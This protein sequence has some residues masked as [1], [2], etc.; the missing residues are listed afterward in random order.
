MTPLALALLFLL[1][2][3]AQSL[4]DPVPLLNGD[5]LNLLRLSRA[6]GAGSATIVPATG[7]GFSSALRL[8]TTALPANS[9]DLRVRA[10]GSAPVR[11]NDSILVTFYA[12][13]VQSATGACIILLNVEQTISPYTKSANIPLVT[14]PDWQLVRYVFSMADTYASGGYMIDFWMSQQ[15]Q[16]IE[17]GA[18][19]FNNYGPGVTAS[20]L[21]IPVYDGAEAGA[22]WRAAALDR[23]E[24][25]RKANLTIS[26]TGPNGNPIP[27]VSVRAAMKRHA[28]GWGTAVAASRLLATGPDSDNYR[29]AILD[30]FNCAV[31]ENDLKWPNW[32]SNRTPALR[33][34]Q[35]LRA[36]GITKIR[37]HNLIW[38]SWGYLP[39]DVRPLQNDPPALRQRIL[40][41]IQDEVS[42]T[43][44]TLMDWDVVNEPFTNT[45]VQRVLGDA[46]LIAWYK[47]ARANDPNVNLYINDY[48]IIEANGAD[49]RHQKGF[50]DIIEFLIA[51]GAPFDGIGIQ[52]H[53]S[54]PTPPARMLSLLDQFAAFNKQLEITEFDF[55]TAD[56]QLQA[57]FTRDL[58]IAAFSHPAIN[59]FLMWGF[60]EGQHWRPQGAMIRRDW[61]AKPNFDVWRDLVYKQWWTDTTAVSDDTGMVRLRGFLGDYDIT[62]TTG[63]ASVTIPATLTRDGA[64]INAVL[65]SAS[66]GPQP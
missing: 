29:Q 14:G 5:P 23:I 53:F 17:L 54:S 46:E 42:A 65:D 22:P 12:R 57:A 66:S 50:S 43:A 47:A 1:H 11:Q 8:A 41:H 32:S 20:A 55:T 64:A 61:S 37:G 19:S 38:P 39:A 62:V 7:P 40:D 51:N 18:I 16:T 25:V 63:A 48:S 33:A 4:S 3:S 49:L 31:L 6:S 59:N 28:F 15:L 58:L 45:D 2:A 21:G 52:G 26:V 34:I 35:W 9:W 36:N 60:W 10:P 13:C 24:Q 44:G 30:N 56:E 27:G